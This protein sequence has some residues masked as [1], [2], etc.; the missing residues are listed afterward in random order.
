MKSQNS[1]EEKKQTALNSFADS[2]YEHKLSELKQEFADK[3]AALDRQKDSAEYDA[4]IIR[5]TFLGTTKIICSK[6]TANELK[7]ESIYFWIKQ[8]GRNTIHLTLCEIISSY[9]SFFRESKFITPGEI[10]SI[11]DFFIDKYPH[12]FR[13]SEMIYFMNQGV[14]GRWGKIYG[15]LTA[16][17]FFEWWVKYEQELA[18]QRENEHIDRKAITRPVAEKIEDLFKDKFMKWNGNQKPMKKE[19]PDE[20]WFKQNITNQP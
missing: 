18:A 7:G 14:A 20:K 19:I 12:S 10:V 9:G 8:L 17:T 13:F 11:A 16:A 6:V 2:F 1:L 3:K 15:D 5:A 4:E